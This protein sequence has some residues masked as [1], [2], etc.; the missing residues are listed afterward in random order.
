MRIW[1]EGW[2]E[3]RFKGGLR[4]SLKGIQTNLQI[5]IVKATILSGLKIGLMVGLINLNASL[6]NRAFR[7]TRP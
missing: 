2:F 7:A 5:D 6:M 1:C 3:A 4:L